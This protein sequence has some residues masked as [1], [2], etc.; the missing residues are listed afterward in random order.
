MKNDRVTIHTI[1]QKLQLSIST[2]SRALRRM[3][4]VNGE[5][6]AAV[7]R[8]AAELDY[9]PN[10]AARHLA[11]HHPRTIGVV[12]P[13]LSYYFYA[14][15]LTSIEAAAME[16][17]YGVV[18]CQSH[19][20]HL[21][22]MSSIQKLLD[23]QVQGLIIALARDTNNYEQLRRL[24]EKQFPLVFFDRYAEGLNAS[25]VIVDNFA[26]AV[27]ATEHLLASGCRRL[28]FLA[29]P[30]NLLLSTQRVAGFRA[31][32]A[33]HGVTVNEAAILHCDFTQEDAIAQT[34]RLLALPQVP[35]G[36]LVVSDR[37]ALPAMHTLQQ[38]GVRIPQDLAIASFNDEPFAALQ[39]PGLTSVS[40]PI[41]EMGAE[42]VR[43]L[44]RQL[45]PA[46]QVPTVETRVLPTTLVIR[47]SSLRHLQVL[48]GYQA[49][50]VVAA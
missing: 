40:Q 2:V 44:L 8:V 4:E 39:S 26:A 30:P 9:Q 20:S 41:R 36:L 19:E 7:Q 42:T 35:D 32:L 33:R 46:P 47:E 3:P 13:N 28:A 48:P 50:Y 22:E 6:L 23:G 11:T 5:T 34:R 43:L 10:Q 37:L 29:G 49:S 16:A 15:M 27:T 25:K 24:T 14:A 1:A 18:V 31:A 12:V 17:G 45:Q 38:H 21:R